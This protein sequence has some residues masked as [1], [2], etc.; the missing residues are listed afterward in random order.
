MKQAK[1]LSENSFFS[2]MEA[3][4][5]YLASHPDCQCCLPYDIFVYQTSNKDRAE[6]SRSP[7]ITT[8]TLFQPKNEFETQMNEAK[9]KAKRFAT[10][11]INDYFDQM[12]EIGRENPMSRHAI[13]ELFSFE[14]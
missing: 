6:R 11:R 7:Y 1:T 3:M 2:L 9:E 4:H 13:V 8:Y 12:I 5:S 10:E 14:R